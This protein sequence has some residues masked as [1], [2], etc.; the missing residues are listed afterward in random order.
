MKRFLSQIDVFLN[1]LNVSVKDR[2]HVEK[3]SK[4]INELKN[5]ID[6]SNDNFENNDFKNNDFE[7][8]DFENNNFEND[9][10]ENNNVRDNNIEDNKIK[11][12][13]KKQDTKLYFSIVR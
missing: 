5:D 6:N 13:K 4:I 2:T 8:N 12:I 1:E 3:I 7:N 9:D 11:D 10:V